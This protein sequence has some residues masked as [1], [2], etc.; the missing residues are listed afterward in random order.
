MSEAISDTGPILHL[1]E[2]GV[3]SV[4]TIFKKVLVSNLVNEELRRYGIDLV[5]EGQRWSELTFEAKTVGQER[6]TELLRELAAFKLH[7]ADASI[8]ALADD[9]RIKP[10]LTDDMELRKALENRGHEAVGSIGVAVRAYKVGKLTR[11]ALEDLIDDLFSRSSLHLSKGFR[12]F[13]RE[14][15][16]AL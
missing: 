10:I 7:R 3:L 16:V 8:I 9:L 5:V 4:L 11:E 1:A 12:Q 2:I 6:V 15:L 14:M 13:V